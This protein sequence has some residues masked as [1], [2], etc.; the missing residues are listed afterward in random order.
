VSPATGQD[1]A[2]SNE[3]SSGI[4]VAIA[5]GTSDS[6]AYAPCGAM[7]STRSPRAKP[8]TPAPTAS[9]SPAKSVPG[10]KGGESPGSPWRRAWMSWKLTA[11]ARLR[12]RI[13][14]GP[15]GG[16]AI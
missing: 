8:L 1:A 9:T 13:W 2:C 5:A 3:T 10:T 6:S 11:I 4:R 14:P 15:T 7:P 12:T 16:S